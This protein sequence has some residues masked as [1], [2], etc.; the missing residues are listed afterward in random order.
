MPHMV[1]SSAV[2]SVKLQIRFSFPRIFLLL[3]IKML[4]SL[5]APLYGL[6]TFLQSGIGNE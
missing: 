3:C 4:T 5:Q 2:T 1:T 6:I